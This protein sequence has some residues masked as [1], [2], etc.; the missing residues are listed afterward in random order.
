MNEYYWRFLLHPFD[1]KTIA[2]E[3]DI[4]ETQKDNIDKKELDESKDIK[5]LATEEGA[6][7]SLIKLADKKHLSKPYKSVGK[8]VEE[9]IT[10]FCLSTFS[11]MPHL[12]QNLD[13]IKL[14]VDKTLDEIDSLTT[15]FEKNDLPL[16]DH[17]FAAFRAGPKKFH[18]AIETLKNIDL[19]LLSYFIAKSGRDNIIKPTDI[20]YE[21]L[22]YFH[23]AD[24]YLRKIEKLDD[25][26]RRLMAIFN[27]TIG[28]FFLKNA[29]SIAFDYFERAEKM[30]L[31]I[32]NPHRA[33][34]VFRINIIAVIPELQ[35]DDKSLAH[36]D[37]WKQLG[38]LGNE[39]TRDVV[40]TKFGKRS[41]SKTLAFEDMKSKPSIVTKEP[42]Y[43]WN[44]SCEEKLNHVFDTEDL[45]G[46]SEDTSNTELLVFASSFFA[47]LKDF[48][49]Q[50][51]IKSK[52][53]FNK[54][55]VS[56][57]IH[58]LQKMSVADKLTLS[59]IANQILIFKRKCV[60]KESPSDKTATTK[61]DES[62]IEYKT[63]LSNINSTHQEA[64]NAVNLL[65]KSK[66]I[67]EKMLNSK[68]ASALLKANITSSSIES[69]QKKLNELKDQQNKLLKMKEAE[70]LK[71]QD[72]LSDL[73]DLKDKVSVLRS[74]LLTKV[75]IF[76]KLEN[77]YKSKF[78]DKDKN[79]NKDK[80]KA[81]TAE[82]RDKKSKI[83][84][85]LEKAKQQREEK[86]NQEKDK[87]REEAKKMQVH[88]KEQRKKKK[89]LKKEQDQ[90]MTVQESTQEIKKSKQ[91]QD[92][93]TPKDQKRAKIG[94][95]QQKYLGHALKYLLYMGFH[96]T[97]YKLRQKDLSTAATESS[98]AKTEGNH[99]PLL[100][101]I[102]H[103]ALLYN[104][105][106]CFHALKVYKNL[107]GHTADSLPKADIDYTRHAIVHAGA[108]DAPQSDVIETG[109]ILYKDLPKDL[110]DRRNARQLQQFTLEQKEIL[111]LIKSYRLAADPERF[112][113]E[114][115][116]P[117]VV[118]D[119]PLFQHLVKYH[120]P[121]QAADIDDKKLLAIVW[122][123][124]VPLIINIMKIVTK[125]F[126]SEPKTKEEIDRF[127]ENFL[128]HFQALKMLLTICGEFRTEEYC[129]TMRKKLLKLQ[130]TGKVSEDIFKNTMGF[131][132]FLKMC[133]SIRNKVAHEFADDCTINE[134]YDAWRMLKSINDTPQLNLNQFSTKPKVFGKLSSSI[135]YESSPSP[136]EE[137]STTEKLINLDE[138]DIE[139]PKAGS[140][141]QSASHNNT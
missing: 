102:T 105:G 104:I 66:T 88:A 64:T 17:L 23:I 44:S 140:P 58:R 97:E 123:K 113:L 16:L 95:M 72:I 111:K 1:K 128:P 55:M 59:E 85:K 29:Y 22:S 56:N 73:N 63:T 139:P 90:L 131:V 43:E 51:L 120:N 27:F 53:T 96:Y 126:E 31:S 61:T 92:N 82:G 4:V 93:N 68:Y 138:S 46:F 112:A 130:K 20:Q 47:K 74:S 37:I 26:D 36:K 15:P 135:W 132:V 49:K 8:A 38:K 119:M 107:G 41:D 33:D 98:E 2:K 100:N 125:T 48:I 122:V 67:I 81:H 79:K 118:E 80:D 87:K 60:S 117:L 99:D 94:E 18:E 89:E 91:G 32:S 50:N 54:S 70:S 13:F 35:F 83:Q 11:I 45:K 84:D 7:V 19:K 3:L 21:G 65:I 25:N 103:F 57:F 40:N 114:G 116:F 62:Q 75:D 110:I 115:G 136:T 77:A 52:L 76:T 129:E 78:K 124:T 134:M 141:E 108:V 24:Q 101:D 10:S 42:Q 86:K 14:Y 12:K 109:E 34:T 9:L 106:R 28:S 5:K 6:K 127:Y 39:I 69:D 71:F 133:R 137:N 121:K 30:I